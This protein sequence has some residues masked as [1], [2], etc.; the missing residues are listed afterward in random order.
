M[1]IQEFYKYSLFANLSYVDWRS[2]SF[3]ENSNLSNAIQDANTAKRV[4]GVFLDSDGL[5]TLGEQIF[6]PSADGGE[7]W[8]VADE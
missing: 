1:I 2:V 3:G 5:N 7:G 6:L 4:P 8:R